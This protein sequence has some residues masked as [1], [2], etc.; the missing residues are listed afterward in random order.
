MGLSVIVSFVSVSC[1]TPTTSCCS[2]RC[3]WVLHMCIDTVCFY[4]VGWLL[5][6]GRQL[7]LFTP[8]A[9]AHPAG[10]CCS[11]RRWLGGGL[12]GVRRVAALRTELGVRTPGIGCGSSRRG[13]MQGVT[14]RVH[15][16]P[17]AN[18]CWPPVSSNPRR[19]RLWW[20]TP[21]SRWQPS[22]G[23]CPTTWSRCVCARLLAA[24][25]SHSAA[26]LSQHFGS[27]GCQKFGQ[28]LAGRL[29]MSIQVLLTASM[30]TAGLS[31]RC[32]ACPSPVGSDSSA[33]AQAAPSSPRAGCSRARLLQL[34]RAWKPAAG[35]PAG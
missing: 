4:C 32:T 1:S 21:R 17:A 8:L 28:L 7:R 19:I 6:P 3:W 24:L 9:A 31:R 15:T 30:R 14:P 18:A 34:Q 22:T 5:H 12:A 20:G 29:L 16:A 25:L 35:L 23:S 11:S 33:L 13:R 10:S 2:S 26:C 27:C